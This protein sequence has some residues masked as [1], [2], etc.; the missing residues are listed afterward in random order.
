MISGRATPVESKYPIRISFRLGNSSEVFTYYKDDPGSEA[1]LAAVQDGD[2]LAAWV[3]AADLGF[4]ETPSFWRLRV[5]D[6]EVASYEDLAAEE[7]HQRSAMW[8]ILGF[9]LFSMFLGIWL[10]RTWR[11]RLQEPGGAVSDEAFGPDT[12]PDDLGLFEEGPPGELEILNAISDLSHGTAA[13]LGCYWDLSKKLRVTFRECIQKKALGLVIRVSHPTDVEVEFLLEWLRT[14]FEP[15]EF[16]AV[17]RRNF[18]DG[19]AFSVHTCG[20]S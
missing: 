14:V 15:V 8:G 2:S 18:R 7:H 10:S 12:Q 16:A 13:V 4:D 1:V 6:V 9:G 3:V 11:K 17:T 5:G 19:S 20:G